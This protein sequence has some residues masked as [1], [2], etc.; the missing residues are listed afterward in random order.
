[1]QWNINNGKKQ[2]M[3][4]EK[5]DKEI[6]ERLHTIF[7]DPQT[8]SRVVDL[9]TTRKRPLNWSRKSN[10]PYYKEVFARQIQR[11]IDRM[12]ETGEAIVYRYDRWC[13]ETGMSEQTLY[14]R[15]NQSIRFLLEVLYVGDTKYNPWYDK[16]KIERVSGLGIRVSYVVGLG[17]AEN[18]SGDFIPQPTDKPRWKLELDAWIESDSQRPFVK[19]GLGLTPQQIEQLKVELNVEGIQASVTSASVKVIKVNS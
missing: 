11:D 14:N 17:V 6:K 16:A 1:M 3:A 9:V 4:D 8:A 10:A 15:I 2:E 7:P 5:T 12:I 13:G 18:F 19:E